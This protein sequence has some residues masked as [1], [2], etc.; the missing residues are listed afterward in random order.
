MKN[1][2]VFTLRQRRA[3]LIVA[4][5]TSGRHVYRNSI[6]VTNRDFS[7]P[8]SVHA[9]SEVRPISNTS[10]KHRDIDWRVIKLTWVWSSGLD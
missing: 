9:G 10:V 1:F 4:G 3:V 2:L 6:P 7:Q 5:L 8:H